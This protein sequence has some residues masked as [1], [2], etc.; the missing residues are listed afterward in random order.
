MSSAFP[1]LMWKVLLNNRLMEKHGDYLWSLV[2]ARW[3]PW[4]IQ[5]AKRYSRLSDIMVD[6]PKSLIKDV[7]IKR[8]HVK[9]DL[10]VNRAAII[11]DTLNDHYY[12]LVKCPWGCTEYY[13]KC[14]HVEFDIL[15]R[16]LLGED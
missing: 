1:A 9:H 8:E 16:R 5:S 3:R 12:P 2:S 13:V 4:W 11:R 10:E 6:Y 14:S 7:T 15:L